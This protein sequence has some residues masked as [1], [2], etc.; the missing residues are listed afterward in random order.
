ENTK[1]LK[2][3]SREGLKFLY[4][5]NI[6]KNINTFIRINSQKSDFYEDDIETIN[7]VLNKN[8]S[9]KGIFLPK[10]DSYDQIKDCYDQIANSNKNNTSIV[11]IIETKKGLDNLENI[12]SKDTERNIIQYVHYGH[13]DYCL[14]NQFWPF[15]EPYHSEYWEIIENISKKIIFYKRKYIHTPFPLIEN[16][17]I[18]WSSIN[19]MKKKLK[20]NEI[21]LSLVNI[22]MSYIN[23]PKEI[24]EAKLKKISND[25][26]YKKIFAEKIVN[27]YLS[28]KSKNKSFS[29]SRKRFIPPHLY[30]GAKNF[31]SKTK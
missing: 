29:L 6:L 1:K 5:K 7:Q 26:D 4:E 10:V 19:H 18:Y 30:L 3:I 16:E 17:N 12:L 14:D 28:N 2:K 13:Y 25:D 22:D 21:N 15:P 20:I 31:L 24:K 8:S 9:I 23:Q 27:E 11:P